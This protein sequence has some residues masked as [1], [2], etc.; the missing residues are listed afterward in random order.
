MGKR[1]FLLEDD[2]GIRDVIELILGLEDYD[3]ISFETVTTFMEANVYEVPDLFILDVML[4]DGNGMDVCAELKSINN[5]IPVLMMSA[6]ASAADVAATC[7]A[8]DFMEKPF[9][10]NKLIEKVNK[11]VA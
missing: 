1:I 5:N 8:N 4:P 10:L 3:V 9:D 2:E 11:L 7:A 6:H